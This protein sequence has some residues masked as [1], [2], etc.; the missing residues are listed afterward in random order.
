MVN[1]PSEFKGAKF[2]V[3]QVSWNNCQE[4]IKKLND[5]NIAPAGL[6]FSLPTEAQWEY[7]CR[8]GTMTTCHLGNT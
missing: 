7:A 8:A 5:L 6:K 4:Y 3:V 1:N 2:P